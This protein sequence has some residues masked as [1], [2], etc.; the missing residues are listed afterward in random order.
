MKFARDINLNDFD[1][2]LTFPLVSPVGEN[3]PSFS[4]ISQ[5][6]SIFGDPLTFPPMSL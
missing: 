6:L 1:Y 5:H 2:P 3:V 4:D